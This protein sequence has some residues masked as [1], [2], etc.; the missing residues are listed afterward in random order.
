MAESVSNVFSINSYLLRLMD[1][2][3]RYKNRNLESKVLLLTSL[4]EQTRY[5]PDIFLDATLKGEDPV[6]VLRID[7]GIEFSAVGSVNFN[8][9]LYDAQKD[10]YT[11]K[12]KKIFDELSSLE[13]LNAKDRLQLLGIKIYIDLFKIQETIKQYNLLLKY[14]NKITKIAIDRASKGLGGIYD[15]TQ[16][17]ND[18]INIKLKLVDLK[19]K[20]IQKEY[21]FRQAINLESGSFISLKQLDYK[22]LEVSLNELQHRAINRNSSL[23]LKNKR[24]ELSQSDI[25]VEKS[26]RGLS[27]D[28]QSNY[29]Y[30]YMQQYN[31]YYTDRANSDD[32][33]S[34]AISVKYPIY[35]RN[36]IKL[37]TQRSKIKALQAKNGVE[38]ERRALNRTINR[39]Y[40]MLQKYKIKNQLFLQQKKVLQERI[41]ITYNR[42]R[43]ALESY[44]PYSDS[45][46][47]MARS[48]EAY[49]NNSLS[50]DETTL[51]LYILS[52][53]S[54]LE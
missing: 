45:L 18:L 5:N 51:Q 20:L 26:K 22:S 34:A 23:R 9:R 16:A 43:E 31:N 48:D 41:K 1:E 17:V 10:I 49:I 8:M 39:L 12:R 29:G 13:V 50:I 46:R 28:F 21:L 2:D 37:Q 24:F 52:G 27:V 40:N 36:E 4:I 35:Q 38:I 3:I 33:W 7:E 15:K 25:D 30:G 11:S 54:I 42:Y 6:N 19:E 14:Q 44:K 32:T 47:D 53:S